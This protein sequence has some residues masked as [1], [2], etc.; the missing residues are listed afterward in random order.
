VGAVEVNTIVE[1]P[2]DIVEPTP[3]VK[4]VQVKVLLPSVRVPPLILATLLLVVVTLKLFV[5][6]VPFVKVN[7]P[8]TVN[9]LPRVIP[10]DAWLNVAV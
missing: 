2:A 4:F 6:N 3:L 9:A 8:V 7:C 1:V 5:T 10:P